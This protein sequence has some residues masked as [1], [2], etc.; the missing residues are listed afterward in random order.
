M[1]VRYT[2]FLFVIGILG[3]CLGIVEWFGLYCN[4]KSESA[5]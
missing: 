4:I 2:E 5:Q 1:E 3:V